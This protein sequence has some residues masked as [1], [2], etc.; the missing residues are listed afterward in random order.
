MIEENEKWKRRNLR[1]YWKHFGLTKNGSKGKLLILQQT[2][3]MDCAENIS[4]H[5]EQYYHI[6][7]ER[8]G[9]G[10][11]SYCNFRY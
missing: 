1:W 8:C 11:S 9:W 5:F 10:Y 3:G 2:F 4:A 7:C 6:R